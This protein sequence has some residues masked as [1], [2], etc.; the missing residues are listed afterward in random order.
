M[1]LTTSS[2]MPL[3]AADRI[4]ARFQP[5]VHAPAAGRAASRMAHS[6]PP[7]APTSDSMCPASDS[8]ARDP[9]STA[10]MISAS[11]NAASRASA[12]SR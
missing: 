4:S 12:I 3:A 7:I 10:T 11:M 5:N 9:D 2:V 6:A 8:R 1:P